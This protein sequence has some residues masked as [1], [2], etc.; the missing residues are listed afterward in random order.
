MI[1]IR[2]LEFAYPDSGFRLDIPSFALRD[3]ETGEPIDWALLEYQ[4]H[5]GVQAL[6]RDLNRLYRELPALHR[7]NFEQQGFEWIDYHD[8]DHSVLSLIRHGSGQALVCLFNFTPVPRQGYRV[9][10][11]DQN[12]LP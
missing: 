1:D 2:A 12:P 10:D 9:A 5:G 11:G 6:V 7:H 4:T 3:V 8:A